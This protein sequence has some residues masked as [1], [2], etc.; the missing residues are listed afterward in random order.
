MGFW[1]CVS[2]WLALSVECERKG[3][4]WT[5]CILWYWLHP[6]IYQDTKTQYFLYCEVFDKG[7]ANKAKEAHASIS[8]NTGQCG[9]CSQECGCER[10]ATSPETGVP[11]PTPR[12][13][14]TSTANMHQSSV[15]G[16]NLE[17]VRA[18][19]TAQLFWGL[20]E[21]EAVPSTLGLQLFLLIL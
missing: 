5:I 10:R 14:W 19:E 17:K 11:H 6:W 13:P 1:A 12:R 9:C 18:L 20:E 4:T 15:L 2:V 3:A 7:R 16:E 8:L 21:T